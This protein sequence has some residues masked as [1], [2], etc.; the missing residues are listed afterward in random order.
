[1][2]VEL[3]SEQVPGFM[4]VELTGWE[5]E[6]LARGE[7]VV[8]EFNLLGPDSFLNIQDLRY[9][10]G[11]RKQEVLAGGLA[12]AH[13]FE[14]NDITLHVPEIKRSYFTRVPI[15]IERIHGDNPTVER[16]LRGRLPSKGIMLLFG[17]SWQDSAYDLFPKPDSEHG[18]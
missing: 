14:Q 11:P 1:M 10:S 6:A 16:E 15:A 9:Y 5:S 2:K 7:G 4:G 8:Q 17:R 18:K 13:V 3:H 12:V